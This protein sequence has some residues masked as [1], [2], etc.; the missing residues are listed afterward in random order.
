MQSDGNIGQAALPHN[1]QRVE[2]EENLDAEMWISNVLTLNC[3]VDRFNGFVKESYVSSAKRKKIWLFRKTI[4]SE[5]WLCLDISTLK[6]KVPEI[7]G[8]VG[9]MRSE[10]SAVP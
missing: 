3:G 5:K 9:K 2:N 10:P 4:S 7:I 1:D 6:T 8:L